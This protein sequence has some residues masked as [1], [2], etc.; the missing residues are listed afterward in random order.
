M[1]Q[2][3]LLLENV[4]LICPWRNSDVE[5]LPIYSSMPWLTNGNMS[6]RM[7]FG[8]PASELLML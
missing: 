1:L 4:D 8:H 6:L 5:A 7:T 3:S 2:N